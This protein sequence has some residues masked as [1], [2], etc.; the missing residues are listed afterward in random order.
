MQLAIG[1]LW[2]VGFFHGMFD[3]SNPFLSVG[4]WLCLLLGAAVQFVLLLRCKSRR[5]RGSFAALLIALLVACEFACQAITG[6]DLL[7][8]LIIYGG[9]LVMLLGA[10][11]CTLIWKIIKIKKKTG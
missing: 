8:W 5:W 4:I 7:G 1:Q 10:G 9:M 11:I 2:E 3:F 6:W